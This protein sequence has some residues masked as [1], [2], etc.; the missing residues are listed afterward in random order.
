MTI[1]MAEY[2]ANRREERRTK[3]VKLAGSQC[4]KCGS[5]ED[6]EFNHLDRTQKS[7]SLSGAGLDGT[8]Q[9]IL[10]ELNKCELLCHSCHLDY[11]AQQY[12]N[13]EITAHNKNNDPYIH[14]T[15][16]MYQEAKCKCKL[17]REAK[18]RYR[19][20]ET[21]YSGEATVGAVATSC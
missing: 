21:N 20:K 4:S 12:K 2:M 7:F 18:R 5:L 13:K 10:N 11:T 19:N 6:L 1:N 17:C 15:M 9:S 16:R 3:L 14:G 8:W